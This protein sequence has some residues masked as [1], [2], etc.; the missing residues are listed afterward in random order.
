MLSTEDEVGRKRLTNCFMQ[1]RYASA[2]NGGISCNVRYKLFVLNQY[3]VF[4]EI[5]YT[6]LSMA[7]FQTCTQLPVNFC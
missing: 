1:C 5:A 7:A 2:Q 6:L 3:I 4:P